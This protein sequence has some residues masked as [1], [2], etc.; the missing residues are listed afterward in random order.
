MNESQVRE[1]C[2][3]TEE[4]RGEKAAKLRVQR[5]MMNRLTTSLT[6]KSLLLLLKSQNRQR[7][8]EWEASLSSRE[9]T[10]NKSVFS[11]KD[12]LLKSLDEEEVCWERLLW[13]TRVDTTRKSGH[14]TNSERTRRCQSLNN[15]IKLAQWLKVRRDHMTLHSLSATEL[16]SRYCR[17]CCPCN[18]MK[19]NVSLH[20]S[21]L[22]QVILLLFKHSIL[23][24]VFVVLGSK[25]RPRGNKQQFISDIKW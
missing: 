15:N 10:P 5:I 6:C 12:C 21:H 18:E 25:Q 19:W 23:C 20:A 22:P 17:I 7:R 14:S 1:T 11:V 3:V 8:T 4:K 16:K 24:L 2:W 13:D 9:W